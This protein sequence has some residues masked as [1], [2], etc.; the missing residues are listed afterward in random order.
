MSPYSPIVATLGFILSPERTH[1]LLVHRNARE[2]DL[3]LGKFNGLGGKMRSMKALWI[4]CAVKSEKKRGLNVW[5]Y[6]CA[7]Q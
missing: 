4:V 5:K 7:A 2:E 6:V 3:H 1:T